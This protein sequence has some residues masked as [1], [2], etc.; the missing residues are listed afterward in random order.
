MTSN[1]S[2]TTV[3]GMAV[4]GDERAGLVEETDQRDEELAVDVAHTLFNHE[5]D[6][7]PDVPER[8]TPDFARTAVLT[9]ARLH[10]ERG[11][12]LYKKAFRRARRI[13]SSQSEH[14]YQGVLEVIQNADDQGATFLDM[15]VE[16]GRLLFSHDGRRVGVRDVL[17]MAFPYVTNKEDRSDTTGRFGIGLK[18]LDRLGL[19]LSV[20]CEPYNFSISRDDLEWIASPPVPMGNGDGSR[21][22]LSLELSPEVDTAKL[23]NWL[24]SLSYPVL[25]F[26]RSVKAIRVQVGQRVQ[27]I[28]LVA[29]RPARMPSGIVSET[30]TA[31]D[32]RAWTRYS[33]DVSLVGDGP[34]PV[35]KRVDDHTWVAIAVP[36]QDESGAVY[37]RLPTTLVGGLPWSLNADFEPTADRE[38]IVDSSWNAWLLAEVFRLSLDV[39]LN[40][41][42]RAPRRAWRLLALPAG[43]DVGYSHSFRELAGEPL[44]KTL[45]DAGVELRISV[46][47]V[48]TALDR[49]VYEAVELKN[50]VS[51]VDLRL[52]RPSY[53]PLQTTARDAPGRWRSVLET[54]GASQQVSVVDSL[55]LLREEDGPPAAQ[56]VSL[57]A[58]AIGAGHERILMTMP[59]LVTD[60]GARLTV[61][62]ARSALVVQRPLGNVL[63]VRL[64]LAVQIHQEYLRGTRA[65]TVVREWLEAQGALSDRTTALQILTSLATRGASES[66]V[67]TVDD[68]RALRDELVKLDDSERSRLGRR[69]GQ[70]ILVDGYAFVNGERH[71]IKLKPVNGYLPRTIDK[72]DDGMSWA[73]AAGETPGLEWISP[74]YGDPLSGQRSGDRFGAAALFRLL[75][76]ENAPRLE[77]APKTKYLREEGAY[78]LSFNRMPEMQLRAAKNLPRWPEVLLDDYHSPHL[79]AVVRDIASSPPSEVRTR[80]ARALLAVLTRSWERLRTRKTAGAAYAYY[81]FN[82]IGTVPSTWVADAASIPWV[83]NKAGGLARP[84]D[85][86]LDTHDNVLVFEGRPSQFLAEAHAGE[87]FSEDVLRALGVG[88]DPETSSVVAQLEEMRDGHEERPVTDGEVGRLYQILAGRCTVARGRRIGDVS[89]E[90]LRG[91]FGIDPGRPGLVYA[92]GHWLSPNAVFLGMPI[93]KSRRAFVPDR[94]GTSALWQFLGIRRPGIQDCTNVLDEISKVGEPTGDDEAVMIDSYAAI[95]EA[96]PDSSRR[97][98]QAVSSMAL[99]TGTDWNTGPIFAIDGAVDLHVALSEQVPVWTALRPQT[100][101]LLCQARG[102]RLLDRALFA[103]YDLPVD[104]LLERPGT[105]DTFRTAITHLGDILAVRSK[106][107]YAAC[108]PGWDTLPLSHVLIAPDLTLQ[109]NVPTGA[110]LRFRAPAHVI[111]DGVPTF[112]FRSEEAIGDIDIGGAVIASLFPTASADAAVD[113]LWAYAWTKAAS[114]KEARG[115]RLASDPAKPEHKPIETETA[116]ATRGGRRQVTSNAAAIKSLTK[117]SPPPD[118]PTEPP[119]RQ[120][121]SFQNASVAVAIEGED[122]SPGIVKK[123]RKRQPLK[124]NPSEPDQESPESR[125]TGR[126]AYTDEERQQAGIDTFTEVVR[127]LGREVKPYHRQHGVGSDLRD[128]DGRY[129]ELKVSGQEMPNEV[130]LELTEFERARTE[131]ERYVLVVVSGVERGYETQIKMFPDPIF[132]LDVRSTR[133]LALSGVRS[134]TAKVYK[135][136]TGV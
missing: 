23:V 5:G 101:P 65:S 136:R 87:P 119:P 111:V 120:L 12:G 25:L 48:P 73:L 58:L 6:S 85:V 94:A 19:P 78:E 77:A 68:L 57:C 21:T 54:I 104:A 27:E 44:N 34:H 29:S 117:A 39:A 61:A 26:L 14:R 79:S 91:K 118:R 121:K 122:V 92:D 24:H 132:S 125:G 133:G 1:P 126:R 97:D 16:G 63:A 134:K 8:W 102:V 40:L 10:R 128:N 83:T 35:D 11:R 81:S 2:P 49:L 115:I 56:V 100:L 15:R 64:G 107:T 76:A 113:A 131:R 110:A 90:Q 33:R 93:F 135:L 50:V 82:R 109:G 74:R 75:G 31:A 38:S 52:L 17:P 37:V 62:A 22:Y 55:D 86:V 127:G 114:G 70:G 95:E 9:F 7:W 106:S 36:R 112:Y 18:T 42:T 41:G 98:R 123:S 47:D 71:D 72:Q 108:E 3:S 129:Y 53:V 66:I 96:L 28:R 51:A 124:L 88:L 69:L 105:Q 43:L 67:L 89:R 59:C 84:C 45:A 80:R 30:L 116:L 60:G 13:A 20:Y 130:N 4:V 32:G 103:P 46:D 99:W